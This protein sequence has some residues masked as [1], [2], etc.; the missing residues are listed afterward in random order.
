I[1]WLMKGSILQLRGSEKICT[2]T[3]MAMVLQEEWDKITIDEIN[4]EIGKLPRIMQQCI[5]QSGGN[6]FQA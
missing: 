4:R 1:W 2:T 3:P 5:E 6:K